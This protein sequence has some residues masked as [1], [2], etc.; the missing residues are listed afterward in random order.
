MP[1]RVAKTLK[2]SFLYDKQSN[3]DLTISLRPPHIITKPM[4]EDTNSYDRL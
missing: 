4:F 2:Y 1:F 3:L